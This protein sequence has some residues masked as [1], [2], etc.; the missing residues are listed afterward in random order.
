MKRPFSCDVDD[1]PLLSIRGFASPHVKEE[2]SRQPWQER[3]MV[4]SL[5]SLPALSSSQFHCILFKFILNLPLTFTLHV[6]AFHAHSLWFSFL[7]FSTCT[8]VRRSATWQ[9]S[10]PSYGTAISS[11]TIPRR[12]K[13]PP[14][15]ITARLE[16]CKALNPHGIDGS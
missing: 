3:Q 8:R 1:R 5:V 12:L 16:R 15:S 14:P 10:S 7:L 2:R 9:R 13:V 4:K 11:S 6:S